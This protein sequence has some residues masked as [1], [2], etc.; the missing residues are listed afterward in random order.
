[1]SQPLEY[2]HGT[3]RGVIGI[4]IG[5]GGIVSTSR[6]ARAISPSGFGLQDHGAESEAVN[7]D[8]A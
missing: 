8:G 4:G 5:I 3:W 1:M 2:H 7:G 6:R